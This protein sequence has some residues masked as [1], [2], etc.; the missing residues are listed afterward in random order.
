MCSSVVF[1]L[2]FKKCLKEGCVWMWQLLWQRNAT[3]GNDGA[4]CGGEPA[5]WIIYTPLLFRAIW[6]L[7]AWD[8]W[9]SRSPCVGTGSVKLFIY[10][11]L[12]SYIANCLYNYKVQLFYMDMWTLSMKYDVEITTFCNVWPQI[13]HPPPPLT[14]FGLFLI[15]IVK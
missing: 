7:M 13:P 10:V 1:L 12:L 3:P 8:V 4:P 2:R 14:F 15:R 9:L 11:G 5:A 6:S